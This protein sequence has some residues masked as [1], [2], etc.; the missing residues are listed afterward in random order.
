MTGHDLLRDAR[1]RKPF[2]HAHA[3]DQPTPELCLGW[4][5]GMDARDVRESLGRRLQRHL[6]HSRTRAGPH[7]FRREDGGKDCATETRGFF[8]K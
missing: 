6:H 7:P 8:Q 2:P 4:Y 1:R 3:D 5:K